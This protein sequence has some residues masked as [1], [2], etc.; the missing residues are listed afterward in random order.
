MGVT[1]RALI[2]T[3]LVVFTLQLSGCGKLDHEQVRKLAEQ[4]W[5][6]YQNKLGIM[7]ESGDG[8]P[9]DFKKAAYWYHEAAIQNNAAAQL[10][11]GV[12]HYHGKGVRQDLNLAVNYIQRS[13]NQRFPLALNILGRMYEK[14]EGVD[15]NNMIAYALFNAAAALAKKDKRYMQ[16]RDNALNHLSKSEIENSQQIASDLLGNGDV[17]KIIQ[18][19]MGR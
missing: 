15:Q 16:D 13:A 4:G 6:K 17:I 5:E 9:Q 12:L 18:M 19:G 2:S 14:G 11:L 10:N 3:V 8:V 1:M 7:Y